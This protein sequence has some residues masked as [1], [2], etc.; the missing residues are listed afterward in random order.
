ME[1]LVALIL[2]DAYMVR[3]YSRSKQRRRQAIKKLGATIL[4]AFSQSDDHEPL[5][6]AILDALR[7]QDRPPPF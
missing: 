2:N 1:E 6:E 5:I 3:H 7:P 4:F